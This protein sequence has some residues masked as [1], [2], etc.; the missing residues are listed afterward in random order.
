[1]NH[2]FSYV[3]F[4]LSDLSDVSRAFFPAV[5]TNPISCPDKI[6]VSNE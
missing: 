2:V 4:P 5:L 1:M 3:S 6:T